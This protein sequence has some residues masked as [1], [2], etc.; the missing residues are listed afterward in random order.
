AEAAARG[1]EVALVAANVSGDVLAEARHPHV[2]IV[3]VG[4]A[5]E[6]SAAMKEESA[7]ADVVLMAA[8]VADYRPVEVSA[9]KLTKD[10]GGV[11]TIEL[12][13]NE[14]IV[15]ALVEKRGAGQLIVAFA[16]E[17]PED[18]AEMLA[19]ARGKQ[20]RKGVDLL[21]VNEVGWEQ[22]FERGENAVHILGPGG[23]VARTAAGSK[24]EVA[25]AVWDEVA[26]E[27]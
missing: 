10:R 22:G 8:A 1:A 18:E 19:R 21:V 3:R 13:E 11:G 4:T 12:V 16:A 20:E 27:R 14:D 6:L 5:A 15:A 17:T 9:R 7:A 23:V 24:R 2:R 26:R 25:A